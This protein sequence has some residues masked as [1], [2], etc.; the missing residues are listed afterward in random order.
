MDRASG[1]ELEFD[2][3]RATR[4]RTRGLRRFR[5]TDSSLDWKNRFCRNGFAVGLRLVHLQQ[6]ERLAVYDSF[7]RDDEN[8]ASRTARRRAA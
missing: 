5:R 2:S 3:F 7:G 6:S 4:R 1:N 8:P